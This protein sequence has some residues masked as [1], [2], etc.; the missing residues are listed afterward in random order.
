MVSEET[1]RLAEISDKLFGDSLMSDLAG[2]FDYAEPADEAIELV[3]AACDDE[4]TRLY[5]HNSF[6]FMMPTRPLRRDPTFAL[7][8]EHVRELAERVRD[9]GDIRDPTKAEVIG[10]LRDAFQKGPLRRNGQLVYIRLFNDLFP[11]KLDGVALEDTGFLNEFYDSDFKE[12]LREI[13]K[14]VRKVIPESHA[15]LEQWKEV[16]DGRRWWHERGTE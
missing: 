1:K 13:T 11:G 10:F 9:K 5:V 6:I 12:A 7:Y 3:T 4:E 2:L 14:T 8:K 16:K 15:R